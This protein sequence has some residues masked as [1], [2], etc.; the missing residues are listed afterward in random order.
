MELK[1]IS[2]WV[3]IISLGLWLI[4]FLMA[5]F[6]ESQPINPTPID[7]EMLKVIMHSI[8]V[9]ASLSLIIFGIKQNGRN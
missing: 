7:P 3:G 2:F 1:K 6:P 5:S 4:W 9:G 8:F